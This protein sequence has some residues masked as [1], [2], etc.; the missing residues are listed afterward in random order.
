MDP[1]ACSVDGCDD[2]QRCKGFCN[3]HYKRWRQDGDPGEPEPR[4]QRRDKICTIDGCEQAH[5]ARG[6][7]R[8]HLQ[9]WQTHGDPNTVKVIH[10]HDEERFWRQVEKTPS[11]WIWTGAKDWDGYG[12]SRV[13]GRVGRAHRESLAWEIGPL[14]AV[15]EKGKRLVV[16]HL[17]HNPACVNP[18]HLELVTDRVNVVE[19]GSG[20]T[21]VNARKTHC[22][23][24][25]PLT[26][27]NAYVSNG[28]RSCVE[29]RR[30]RSRKVA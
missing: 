25:H 18:D 26:E 8:K 13:N 22:K 3:R 5:H 11:C 24:G 9:R 2:P 28:M 15:N 10:G 23:R 12:V 1:K 16:D 6:W 27:D 21:A 30:N 4:R 20:P 29:C 17:C 14:P 19:R 7:C